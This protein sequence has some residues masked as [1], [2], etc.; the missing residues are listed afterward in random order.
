M[1][2]VVDMNRKIYVLIFLLTLTLFSYSNSMAR[3]ADEHHPLW[4]S[5]LTGIFVE[6]HGPWQ[7]YPGE[8]I[9]IEI[10]VEAEEDVKNMSMDLF[11]YGSMSE[12]YAYWNFAHP[13]FFDSLDLLK[14]DV[15]VYTLDVLIPHEVSPG[16]TYAKIAIYW[17]V[18]RQPFWVEHSE[19][20]NFR[21]MYLRNKQ[22]EIT[23][24]LMY[25]FVISTVALS[26]S[27]AFMFAKSRK[28]RQR[29]RQAF[30]TND[31]KKLLT[32]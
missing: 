27:N 32:P 16:L 8:K 20:D 4:H 24:M 6:T 3:A 28:M 30:K 7:S 2:E 23:T 17:S 12:G 19:K 1:R 29:L 9:S 14:D 26:I 15:R 25:A 10:M 31:K 18:Y 13:N 11:I 5:F 22:Y 21:T